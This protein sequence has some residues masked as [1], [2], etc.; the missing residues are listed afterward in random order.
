MTAVVPAPV[1]KGVIVWAAMQAQVPVPS[2]TGMVN[3]FAGVLPAATAERLERLVTSVRTRSGGEIAVV[4]LKDLGGREA[5]D[6]ALQIGREWKVGA[7]AKIGDKARNAGVILLVVPK[8]SSADR[9]GHMYIATG[10]GAE[11][12]ITDAVAGD[13][14][15]E[16]MPALRAADYA[17][18]ITLM[19]QRIA[20]RY[21]AEF[22]FTLDSAD[23]Q[24]MA[25]PRAPPRRSGGF[26]PVLF[27]VAIMIIFIVLS[28]M[29]RRRGGGG[30]IFYGGGGWGSGGGWS[31][32]GG[33]GGG[34]GFGGFGG[35][36]GFSGGGSGGDW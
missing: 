3:D 17:T 19:T 28:S 15:R 10:Q 11:G 16:A 8:E 13:I 35:G 36:G 18:A 2:P 24:R 22:G 31:S 34:G 12:F 5:G 9:K 27:I 4:T 23:V 1:L 30:G 21:A 26:S 20:E 29:S 33:G 6:V 25:Q 7:N 32:G 14:R